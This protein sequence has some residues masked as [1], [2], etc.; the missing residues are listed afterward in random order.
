VEGG[1]GVA[2]ELAEREFERMI[3][4]VVLESCPDDEL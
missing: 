1:Y 3:T 2:M 4:P